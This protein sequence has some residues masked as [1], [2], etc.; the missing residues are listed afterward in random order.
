MRVTRNILLAA[1]LVMAGASLACAADAPD[2]HD[3]HHAHGD[4]DVSG[5]GGRTVGA[6]M[7]PRLR[8]M[9]IQEMMALLDASKQMLEALIRG[10]NDVV[11]R[12]AQNIHDSFILE[13]AMSDAD[14]QAFHDSVPH[15]FIER[16]Q[17]FHELSERLAEAARAG[18]QP[19]QRKLF[20]ELLN[21]CTDCHAAHATDRFPNLA[22]GAQQHSLVPE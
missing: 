14:R 6:Q 10:Q 11:A 4:H 16:D 19:L 7:P 13:Q 15:A 3:A 2:T 20:T 1:V 18:N 5:A 17:A 9:L 12:N 22:V 21:A 8:G